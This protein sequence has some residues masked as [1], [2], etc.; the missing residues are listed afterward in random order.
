[1][2]SKDMKGTL[3]QFGHP[4]SQRRNTAKVR[5]DNG[6]KDQW[7]PVTMLYKILLPKERT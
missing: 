3:E 4:E 5:W 6:H 1:M 2:L 7:W